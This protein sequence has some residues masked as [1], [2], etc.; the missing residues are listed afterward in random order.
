MD[1]LRDVSKFRRRGRCCEILTKKNWTLQ[2]QITFSRQ[3][4]SSKGPPECR[5]YWHLGIKG[6]HFKNARKCWTQGG[7]NFSHTLE[8]TLFGAG[9]DFMPKR[10]PMECAWKK[11]WRRTRGGEIIERGITTRRAGWCCL[12]QREQGERWGFSPRIRSGGQ[13]QDFRYL[14]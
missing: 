5:Q 7:L 10:K 4:M 1:L 12:S 13:K 8:Q 9:N 14:L 3:Q 6:P 11:D 2:S